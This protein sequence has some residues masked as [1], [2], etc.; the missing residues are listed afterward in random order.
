MTDSQKLDYLIE[1]MTGVKA[2]I[3]E[4]KEDIA[5]LKED[6]AGLKE[7]VAVLKE[8][9][10][11]LKEDVAVLK[12]DVAVLKEDVAGLKEDVAGLKEDVAVLKEDVAV[13]KEDVA[14]LQERM[15]KQE[16]EIRYIRTFQEN[17]LEKGI[18]IIAEGH[19]MLLRRLNE[20]LKITEDDEMLRLRVNVLECDM[21]RVKEKLA[22]G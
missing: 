18:K 1:Q 6:V 4:M 12:E 19:V 3:T 8:D 10:A 17:N 22:V 20:A 14:G 21:S 16:N 11:G 9:V 13:L 7:D 2:E 15:D 5:G